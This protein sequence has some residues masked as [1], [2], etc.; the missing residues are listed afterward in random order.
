[1]EVVEGRE[2]REEVGRH[3]WRR[4]GEV[5][6]DVEPEPDVAGAAVDQT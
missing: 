2:R 6:V 1:M 3:W 4:R 5:F